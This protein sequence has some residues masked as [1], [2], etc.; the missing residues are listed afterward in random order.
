MLAVRFG[1]KKVI[2]KLIDAKA[3]VNAS[4]KVL[5]IFEELHDTMGF[6]LA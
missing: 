1:R 4:N 3:N 5:H 6:T 2:E